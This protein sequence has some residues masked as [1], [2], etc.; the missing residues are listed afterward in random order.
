MAR[1]FDEGA[2]AM[3]RAA[4][5]AVRAE[6]VAQLI[7]HRACCSSEHDPAKGKLHGY[8]VICGVPWP[9]A[10]A[11]TPPS[12]VD[13]SRDISTY[14]QNLWIREML[15]LVEQYNQTR[16]GTP[17]KAQVYTDLWKH[18]HNI[19]PHWRARAHFAGVRER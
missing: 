4:I 7:A 10:Y 12:G 2:D 3:E 6:R 14:E 8:C 11:G 16:A 17:S 5:E 9:C 19:G 13:S 1:A 15:K 18:A